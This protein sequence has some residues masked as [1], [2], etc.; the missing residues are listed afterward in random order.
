[1]HMQSYFNLT[2]AYHVSSSM[3]SPDDPY[4]NAAME[5]FFG[6]LQTECLYRAVFTIALRWSSSLPSTSIPT[7][8]SVFHSKRSHSS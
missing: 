1:M 3:F 5:N 2:I 8:P 7:I 6:A 4:D